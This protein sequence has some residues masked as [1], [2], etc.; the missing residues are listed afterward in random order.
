MV[1]IVRFSV[2][3]FVLAAECR[4]ANAQYTR[5]YI[6]AAPGGLSQAGDTKS[7][8]HVGGGIERLL[9]HGIG[10]TAEVEGIIPGRGK[11][12]D[13]VGMVS[14]D[15]CYHFLREQKLNP[16]I[17]GGYSLLFRATTTNLLNFGGGVH[18]WFEDNLGLLLEFRDHIGN[19][20]GLARVHYWEIRL[21]ITFR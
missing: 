16:V 10:A 8:Y 11:V 9:N 4:L 1:R 15:G 20:S 6:F 12:R 21:G 17:S 5:E 18:Y 19:P 3:V 7:D 2:F 14:I 13:T